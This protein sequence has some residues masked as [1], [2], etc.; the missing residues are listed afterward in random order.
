MTYLLVP[1]PV[2]I[3]LETSFDV[4]R[5]ATRLKD[6]EE[7]FPTETYLSNFHRDRSHSLCSPS[8]KKYPRSTIDT[9]PRLPR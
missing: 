5:R 2:T 8:L 6:V 9:S 1:I 3:L 7:R 4:S